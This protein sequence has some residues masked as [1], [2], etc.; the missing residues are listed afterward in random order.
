MD[1]IKLVDVTEE[2][3]KVGHLKLEKIFE[4]QQGLLEHYQAI[5]GLPKP[6]LDVNAKHSQ[7]LIKDFISR[8]IGELSEGFTSQMEIGELTQKNNFWFGIN[9]SE[10]D[11]KLIY[12]L[13][14]N[15][16]EEQAD[17]LHFMCELLIYT[18]ILPEDIRGF[19]FK[20]WTP[21]TGFESQETTAMMDDTLALAMRCGHHEISGLIQYHNS[22]RT[23]SFR[24]ILGDLSEH[25]MR[26]IPGNKFIT[27]GDSSTIEVSHLYLWRITH[28]LHEASHCLKNKPWKQ[29]LVDTNEK[30]L[31]K[32][33]VMAFIIMAGYFQFLGLSSQDVY[34]LYF[35]KNLVNQLRIKNKY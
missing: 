6:P 13:L 33:V 10:E 22:N 2:P 17:A 35:K 31:Q 20:N 32:R 7:A 24:D 34:W 12:P 27:V 30:E 9:Y 23:V 16:F 28:A 5:E 14:Q 29:T 3:P 19:I 21:P 8:C 26:Y 11:A 1:N 25:E 4:L 18:N 15:L